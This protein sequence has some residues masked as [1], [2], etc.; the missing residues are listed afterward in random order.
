MILY[1]SLLIC[2]PV[3]QSHKFFFNLTTN[4]QSDVYAPRQDT[5]TVFVLAYLND[6]S[7]E[8]FL[9][10]LCIIYF[11]TERTKNRKEI[12]SRDEHTKDKENNGTYAPKTQSTSH[13]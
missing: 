8:T 3:I 2:V 13:K 5:N 11:P 1:A 12:W 4:S 10:I 9:K 6:E 7:V